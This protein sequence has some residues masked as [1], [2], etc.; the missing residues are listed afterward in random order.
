MSGRVQGNLKYLSNS[1]FSHILLE[2]SFSCL[3]TLTITDRLL[4]RA[5]YKLEATGP[6]GLRAA[7]SYVACL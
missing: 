2:A 5:S 1:S 7:L 4:A 6:L 3:E